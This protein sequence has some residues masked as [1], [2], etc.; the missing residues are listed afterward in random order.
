MQ[1][2]RVLGLVV[3]FAA[4]ALSRADLVG[5]ELHLPDKLGKAV[6]Y[7]AAT[8]SE[9]KPAVIVVHE[10]WGLNDYAKSRAKMLAEAGYTAIALDMYGTG[11]VAEH[12]D[13][14]KSF[15][16]KALAEPELM[17]ARVETAMLILRQQRG[18]DNNAIYAIGYCFG[19]AVVL[20]QARRGLDLA[21]VAS[22]H[23]SLATETP[24]V[25]GNFKAKVLVANGAVDPFV[26]AE[27]VTGLVAEMAKAGV[28]L[29]L[30]NFATATHG[31][32]NP[33]A[34]AKG[35]KFG[36][37]LAYDAEADKTSWAALLSMLELGYS[38]SP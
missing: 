1:L 14:A 22:F 27:Q 17:N 38:L 34:T 12:P 36:M 37:P 18:V 19:G 10:W 7:R 24:A 26:P 8:S 3:L 15:M 20:Q 23:G 33:D 13:D 6:L 4:S 31:F 16:M 28:D 30:L 25:A 35:K 21:G 5:Q 32:T 29:Q 9:L 11:E 2:K